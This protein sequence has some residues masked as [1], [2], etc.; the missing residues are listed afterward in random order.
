MKQALGLNIKAVN[1][2]GQEIKYKGKKEKGK[3][4]ETFDCFELRERR[5]KNANVMVY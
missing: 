2:T 1:D 3:C 5:D 4:P